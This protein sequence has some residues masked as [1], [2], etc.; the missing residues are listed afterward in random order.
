MA[1][2]FAVWGVTG[3]L[4][5]ISFSSQFDRRFIFAVEMISP[6]TWAL[7]PVHLKE[8]LY[9]HLKRQ[10]HHCCA[11]GLLLITARMTEHK[12]CDILPV[13]LGTEEATRSLT[14]SMHWTEGWFASHRARVGHWDFIMLLRMVHSL[15]F[16]V[17]F[18]NFSFNI[19][20]LRLT[21]DKWNHR[22]QNHG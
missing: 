2:A 18:W 10:H 1:L 16:I 22:K 4:G 6:W 14:G 21:S 19:F 17:Y 12:H 11:L 20:I 9:G 15:K 3:E 13:D 8:A 5:Q 7:S